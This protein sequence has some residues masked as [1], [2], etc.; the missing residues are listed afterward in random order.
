MQYLL[1]PFEKQ[2]D[3]GFGCMGDYYYNAAEMLS[4]EINIILPKCYLYRHSIELIL[5]SLIILI[6]AYFKLPYETPTSH[7]QCFVNGRWKD[8]YK[9]HSLSEL[10][11]YFIEL[12][13][14][15]QKVIITKTKTFDFPFISEEFKTNIDSIAEYDNASDYFRYPISKSKMGDVCKSWLREVT[16]DELNKS[17]KSKN[18]SFTLLVE[19]NDNE[20]IDIYS[21]LGEDPLSDFVDIMQKVAFPLSC[22]H[23][24]MR[25]KMF[26]GS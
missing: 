11:H 17:I 6:H 21:N 12:F 4:N 7:P 8:L 23:I 26:G 2:I 16:P 15:H 22:L 19:N 1:T 13:E 9:T 3:H 20:I 24:A 14:R 5:K 18:K 10:G 25:F